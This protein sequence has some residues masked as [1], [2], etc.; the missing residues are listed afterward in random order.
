[1]TRKEEI[2]QKALTFSSD[3][4]NRRVFEMG[5]EWADKTMLEKV[6]DWVN[7]VIISDY[8]DVRH[9]VLSMFMQFNLESFI[10]DLRKA[11]E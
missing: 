9:A 1:M 10:N 6:C 4:N 2:H 8:V 3:E 7:E 5:A 11:V